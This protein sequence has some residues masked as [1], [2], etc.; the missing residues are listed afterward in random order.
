MKIQFLLLCLI[1]IIV[2][3][4]YKERFN[5]LEVNKYATNNKRINNI[6]ICIE[7]LS[8]FMDCNII[9][10]ESCKISSD[11][12]NSSRFGIGFSNKDSTDIKNKI[13]DNLPKISRCFKLDLKIENFIK[14]NL[15]D[16]NMLEF[17]YAED[18][19]TGAKKIYCGFTD[20]LGQAI[21]YRNNRYTNRV[22]KYEKNNNNTFKILSTLVT[23]DIY[24]YFMTHF[25]DYILYAYHKTDD[26]INTK[27][28]TSIHLITSINL[29]E[30]KP[31]LLK[32]II[33]YNTNNLDEIKDYLD[34]SLNKTVHVIAF[35]KDKN[36]D[37][38]SLY[39]TY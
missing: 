6:L 12:C 7:S 5:L 22:Y 26:R 9:Y 10:D 23:S 14:K 24:N 11:S 15:T 1:V 27:K 36:K 39:L 30:I 18:R 8:S 31:E 20:K 3:K 37:Y 33:K 4:K 35:T 28:I 19:E 32:L 25:K 17:G 2:L 16:G 29:A 38:F 34:N 13:L 21:E